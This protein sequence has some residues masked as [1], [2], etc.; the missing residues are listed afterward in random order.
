MPQSDSLDFDAVAQCLQALGAP[1]E[2]AE[3]HGA[4]CG[5]ACLSGAAALS[6]WARELAP[7]IA[8]SDLQ[9]T[10]RQARLQQLAADALLKLEAG[11]MAFELLLPDAD[12]SL[13]AR[14]A[15]LADWC[16]GFMHGLMAV[17]HPDTGPHWESL[18]SDV[19]REIVD[20]FNAI[21]RAAVDPEAGDESEAALAELVEYVRV[22]AQLMY[23]EAYVLRQRLAGTERPADKHGVS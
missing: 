12:S 4:F 10:A 22:S 16:H 5:M 20:D 8:P 15:A 14:T 6:D 13:S 19:A 17:G 18:D 7:D 23:E 11:Q 2:P 1:W 9:A 21:T 3:A